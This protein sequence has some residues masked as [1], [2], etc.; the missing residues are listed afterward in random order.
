LV[1]DARL[2][3]VAQT[4]YTYDWVGNRAYPGGQEYN[5]A[6]QITASSGH[7]YDY[8]ATGSLHNKY[9][10]SGLVEVNTYTYTPANLLSSVTNSPFGTTSMTWD[11]DNNRVS[12]TSSAGTTYDYVHDITAGIPAVINEIGPSTSVFYIR[13]PDGSLIARL[14]LGI[15]SYYHFDALGSTRLITD[16]S[17]E[18]TDYYS[19]D[20]WGNV[21]HDTGSLSQPYQYV[22]QLG[23]YTHYQD[24]NLPLLQLGVRFY[25]PGLGRFGQRDPLPQYRRNTYGYGHDNP[26]SLRDL[27]LPRFG[28]HPTHAA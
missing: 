23:Y 9:N 1:D 11:A 4:T 10:Q 12:F 17:G 20:A 18:A 25:D 22:G 14:D 28:G 19:Y 13:E 6:D 26:L 24:V 8:Y 7:T 5:A 15:L 3:S 2:A 16:D 21:S 27:I